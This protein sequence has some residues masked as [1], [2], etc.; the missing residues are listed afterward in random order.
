MKSPENV[1]L[2]LAHA[3]E[4]AF[5]LGQLRDECS[6]AAR[7]LMREQ[8]VAEV[9]LEECAQL[10]DALAHAHRQLQVA[11]RRIHA[12]RRQRASRGG[13]TFPRRF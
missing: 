13:P 2:P 3:A 8:P 10:D 9:P 11:L 6:H 5:E 12:A 4:L 1:L 7:V